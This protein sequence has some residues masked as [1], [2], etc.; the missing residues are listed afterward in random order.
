MSRLSTLANLAALGAALLAG[1]WAAA[2]TS[3]PASKPASA[4][5]HRVRM[6]PNTLTLKSGARH[7]P[8]TH[9]HVHDTFHRPTH[10]HGTFAGPRV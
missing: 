4:A 2:A 9:N 6:H 10:I 3:E 7:R 8:R 5:S 1:S